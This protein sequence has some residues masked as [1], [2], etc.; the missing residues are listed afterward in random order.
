MCGVDKSSLTKNELLPFEM[1]EVGLVTFVTCRPVVL[2][3]ANFLENYRTARHLC[4]AAGFPC[5]WNS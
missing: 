3:G 1:G 2:L 4:H 5:D